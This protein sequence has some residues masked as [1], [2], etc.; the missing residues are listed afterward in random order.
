MLIMT[1]LMREVLIRY[2]SFSVPCIS[3]CRY[4]ADE[5]MR[6]CNVLKKAAVHRRLKEGALEQM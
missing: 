5:V 2:S 4:S 6:L 1:G 3:T